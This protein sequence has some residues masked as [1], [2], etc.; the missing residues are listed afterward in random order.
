MKAAQQRGGL[1]TPQMQ[2]NNL[3]MMSPQA[4]MNMNQ[5]QPMNFGQLTPNLDNQQLHLAQQNNL[6]AGNNMNASQPQRS[7]SQSQGQASNSNI[8]YTN[9]GTDVQN[10]IQGWGDNQLLKSTMAVVGKIH[11]AA[12]PSVRS[13]ERSYM[14]MLTISLLAI[15]RS[16]TSFRSSQNG[17]DET[18]NPQPSHCKRQAK[19]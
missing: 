5:S 18:R 12:Q 13:V 3:P 7:M 6:Q 17:K 15:Q 19:R 14:R 2:A 1:V 10:M 11:Q 9:S 4:Q 16:S 8:N